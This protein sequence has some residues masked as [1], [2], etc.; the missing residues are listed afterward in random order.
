MVLI[1]FLLEG[2]K[3][4]FAKVVGMFPLIK[5][6]YGAFAVVPLFLLWV[7]LAWILLLFAEFSYALSHYA[8]VNR[9]LPLLWQRLLLVERVW[10][11]CKRRAQFDRASLIS[12][13]PELT[14]ASQDALAA[15]SAAG[16]PRK[17]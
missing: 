7:Y 17:R 16:L 8:P 14:A 6:I 12:L 3:Y 5:L 13:L 15:F 2:G 11:A 1:A 4:I 9:K 10:R